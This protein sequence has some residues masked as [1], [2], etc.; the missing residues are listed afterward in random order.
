MRYEL[1]HDEKA[2]MYYMDALQLMNGRKR[3]VTFSGVDR[4]GTHE[5]ML[6]CSTMN[7]TTHHIFQDLGGNTV[8]LVYRTLCYIEIVH[9]HY[10]L[11]YR[12]ASIFFTC[13]Q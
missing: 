13:L 3:I 7:N 8:Q 12:S 11:L 9:S 1:I 10:S 5:V 2:T 6:K 4:A